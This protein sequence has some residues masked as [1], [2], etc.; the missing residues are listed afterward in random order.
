MAKK[1]LRDLHGLWI[2]NLQEVHL[3]RLDLD[4]LALGQFDTA[5]T[6]R[7]TFVKPE[8]LH[9]LIWTRQTNRLTFSI[10]YENHEALLRVPSMEDG[11]I[12]PLQ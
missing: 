2:G 1:G 7:V 3:L 8:R 4:E 10:R 5:D 12:P 6:D 9:H 11:R